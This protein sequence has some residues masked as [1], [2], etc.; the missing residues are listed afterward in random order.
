MADQLPRSSIARL[1]IYIVITLLYPFGVVALASSGGAFLPYHH[2]GGYNW[3][4]WFANFLNATTILLLY[5]SLIELPIGLHKNVPRNLVNE[6]TRILVPAWISAVASCLTWLLIL[7]LYFIAGPLGNLTIG[8]TIVAAFAT[9]VLLNPFY[10]WLAQ[11]LWEV[12]LPSLLSLTRWRETIRE[13]V[14]SIGGVSATHSIRKHIAE[15]PDCKQHFEDC[16]AC[17]EMLNEGAFPTGTNAVDFHFMGSS[18]LR[19]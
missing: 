2:G 15:C 4:H 6:R 1:V 18:G 8:Q 13:V 19:V 17:P 7:Q 10:R 16:K 12:E 14:D 11:K 5:L 9:A 3:Q